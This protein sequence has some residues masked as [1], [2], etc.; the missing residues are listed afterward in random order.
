MGRGGA[1]RAFGS[2]SPP[3]RVAG[4]VDRLREAQRMRAGSET[5]VGKGKWRKQWYILGPAQIESNFP[6][7]TALITKE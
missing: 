5:H 3:A 1:R 2:L 4:E 7:K 6:N